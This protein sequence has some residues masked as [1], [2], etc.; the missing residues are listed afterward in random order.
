MHSTMKAEANDEKSSII[1]D[2]LE[3]VIDVKIGS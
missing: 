3:S 2:E 1:F